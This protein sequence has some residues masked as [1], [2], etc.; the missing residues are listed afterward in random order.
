[1]ETVTITT[2]FLT[3]GQLLKE[4]GVIDSGGAAKFYLAEQT[5]L[6]NGEP[7]QRRGRKLYPGDVIALEDGQQ[8]TVAIAE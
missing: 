8:F 4:V 6:V 2:A 7:D 1:M 3:L 5:V